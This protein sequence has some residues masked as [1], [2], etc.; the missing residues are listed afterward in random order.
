[1]NSIEKASELI[2]NGQNVPKRT[3]FVAYIDLHVQHPTIHPDDHLRNDE[4]CPYK[5]WEV[6]LCNQVVNSEVPESLHYLTEFLKLAAIL[7]EL[8]TFHEDIW[9]DSDNDLDYQMW[10][11]IGDVKDWLADMDTKDI[12]I[13]IEALMKLYLYHAQE[14]DTAEE[15]AEKQA[16]TLKTCH[17]V[18]LWIAQQPN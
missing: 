1:M 17:D 3:L 8:D 13:A 10:G 11:N 9:K 4:Y 18:L 16:G 6:I 2:Q 12:H 5:G 7:P 14:G 15:E